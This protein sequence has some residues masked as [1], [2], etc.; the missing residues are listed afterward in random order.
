MVTEDVQRFV[1]A[2]DSAF[3]DSGHPGKSIFS[4]SDYA[5]SDCRYPTWGQPPADGSNGPAKSL[6]EV[7]SVDAATSRARQTA[8]AVIL[9]LH[10]QDPQ[11][12]ALSTL[13]PIIDRAIIRQFLLGYHNI[14]ESLIS[15][16]QPIEPVFTREE[17]TTTAPGSPTLTA[18]DDPDSSMVSLLETAEQRM[19]QAL[20]TQ[21][22]TDTPDAET[23]NESCNMGVISYDSRIYNYT[24]EGEPDDMYDVAHL[25]VDE[26]VSALGEA[27]GSLDSA[28]SAGQHLNCGHDAWIKDVKGARLPTL[29]IYQHVDTYE[30]TRVVAQRLVTAT[31]ATS[32]EADGQ[33]FTD[34]LMH[35]E[36]ARRLTY[37]DRATKP[38]LNCIMA[39]GLRCYGHSVNVS[40]AH[41]FVDYLIEHHIVATCG[42]HRV[43]QFVELSDW[44]VGETQRLRLIK[45]PTPYAAINLILGL[46]DHTHDMR[47]RNPGVSIS[48]HDVIAVMR[49]ELMCVM[50]ETD[51]RFRAT[52]KD[53]NG[54]DATGIIKHPDFDPHISDGGIFLSQRPIAKTTSPSQEKA[55]ASHGT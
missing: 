16:R 31:H 21:V 12:T 48:S 50:L 19:P 9:Q 17:N 8:H 51:S 10:L 7:V 4:D 53:R 55:G 29:N 15:L 33:P 43:G 24:R 37:A 46:N 6:D 26:S 13:L 39:S 41:S 44:L 35:L 5:S 28:V 20:V 54:R 11:R 42:I 23:A 34:D 32:L 14:A 47:R 49:T 45:G 30:F 27:K 2:V 25:A 52:M 22:A 1:N 3:L 18:D 38:L 40:V 36:L